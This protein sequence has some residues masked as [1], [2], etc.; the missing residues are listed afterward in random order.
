M[1]LFDG[2]H[3]KL[4]NVAGEALKEVVQAEMWE[5]TAERMASFKEA[6]G[7][8]SSLREMTMKPHA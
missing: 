2:R 6:A 5:A 3:D 8:V 1:V 7:T 4:C